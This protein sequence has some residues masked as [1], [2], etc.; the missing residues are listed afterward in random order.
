MS[1]TPESTRRPWWSPEASTP[2]FTVPAAFRRSTSPSHR[3]ARGSGRRRRSDRAVRARQL[4]DPRACRIG[5]VDGRRHGL[6]RRSGT[7]RTRP[8][9]G[10]AGGIVPVPKATVETTDHDGGLR[11][12]ART[13]MRDQARRLSGRRPG[14]S[15][16]HVRS[17]V[18]SPQPSRTYSAS[19]A[20]TRPW[21][22]DGTP[23]SYASGRHR[24]AGDVPDGRTRRRHRGGPLLSSPGPGS[25]PV[26]LVHIPPRRTC[27]GLR[28]MP[29]I[30]AGAQQPPTW[31]AGRT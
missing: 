7:R 21:A 13:A 5:T 3:W 14:T 30:D 10:P 25:R 19:S 31:V 8:R 12:R 23:E 15:I 9:P 16:R 17:A 11:L 1:R 24:A 4:Q 29:S 26:P 27:H 18:T 2:T 28:C 20:V 6:L 22:G